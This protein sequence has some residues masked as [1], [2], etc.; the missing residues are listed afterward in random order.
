VEITNSASEEPTIA[1]LPWGDVWEDFFSTIGVDFETF[2]NEVTG[3]WQFG[4]IE[5]LKLVGIRT[6]L[7]YTSTHVTETARFIH[8]PTGSSITVLPVPMSYRKI[9]RRM[10]HSYPSMGYWGSLEDLFGKIP[11]GRRLWFQLLRQIAPYSTTPLRLLAKELRRARCKAIFCQEYEYSRF[12][13]CTLLGKLLSLPVFATFQGGSAECNRIGRFIRP[14]TMKA[15]KGLVIAPQAE[16]DRVRDRY[17]LNSNRIAKIFNP[18]DLKMWEPVEREQ[19]RAFYGF[20]PGAEIVLWHGR[21]HVEEKGLDILLEAWEQ[22]CRERPGRDL[23]LFMMGS[24]EHTEDLRK[25]ISAFPLQNIKWI[26]KYV[27]DRKTMRDF[28]YTGD[29]FAFPSRYEGFPVSPLEAMAC[30]L[31][32]VAS[33]ASGIP[34]IFEN[35]EQSGGVVVPRDDAGSFA[36]ALGRM[37]DDESFRREMG[38]RARQRIEQSFSLEII[39]KQFANLFRL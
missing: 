32:V 14:L 10:I 5:A 16:I 3:G 15:C 18:V 27:N 2:C 37:L 28:L 24:A 8:K 35:G 19:M 26:D 7:I 21:V 31:P 29:V 38:K 34:D 20:K 13:Q 30:G 33:A 39:G 6:L 9:R 36:A 17:H 1:L 23:H 22:V 25:R 11:P 12:D 4:Y